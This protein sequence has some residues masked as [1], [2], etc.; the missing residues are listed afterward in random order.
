LPI[1]LSEP[2]QQP[3]QKI[4]QNCLALPLCETGAFD[5]LPNADAAERHQHADERF[6]WFL[7]DNRFLDE[8]LD[9][10]VN[11]FEEIIE[12]WNPIAIVGCSGQS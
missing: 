1:S 4:D 10:S 5:P 11:R 2:K 7:M 3:N 12:F 9:S 6:G 8:G